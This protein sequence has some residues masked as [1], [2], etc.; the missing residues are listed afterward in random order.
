M[1]K[2]LGAD[3]M[4]FTLAEVLITLGVIGIVAAMTIPT[5]IAN[6]QKKV[7]VNRLKKTFAL[8]SN[9][10]RLSESEND[11][12]S[13]WI[14]PQ[15]KQIEIFDKYLAPYL[16]VSKSE[17]VAGSLNFY[18]PGGQRENG[19]AIVRGGAY[20]YTLLS[21]VDIF[22]N[23]GAIVGL[24]PC[25]TCGTGMLL[26]V[27]LNG[28]KTKPNRFGRDI[29]GIMIST[30]KG[31]LLDY[32]DDGEMG[33]IQRTREQLLNGPSNENYQCNKEGRGL[34]CG[35]LIK[36]DGWKISKDYPW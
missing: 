4:A 30:N 17:A 23:S 16:K 25:P 3:K 29:F 24:D 22:V 10:V 27:D 26:I 21:G 31:V 28:Y 15:T 9:A 13:G 7:T 2:F 5:L 18:S 14:V 11:A 32:S 19:F 6:Y 35:A 33:S 8:V 1:F 20:V 34:W 36:E 12:I